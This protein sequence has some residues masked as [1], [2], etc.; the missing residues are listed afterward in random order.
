MKKLGNTQMIITRTMDNTLVWDWFAKHHGPY[1]RNWLVSG[2]GLSKYN[3][4]LLTENYGNFLVGLTSTQ[5]YHSLCLNNKKRWETTQ[6][7]RYMYQLRNEI[8]VS[9]NALRY[10][11]TQIL[12]TVPFMNVLLKTN[13]MHFFSSKLISY[14]V[15]ITA[16]F[17]YT[18]RL[19]LVTKSKA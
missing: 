8:K 11:F 17:I 12:W 13:I 5:Y 7:C 9:L 2:W 14:K 19:S 18:I 3:V 1:Y 16:K 15:I 10:T 4:Y 6:V